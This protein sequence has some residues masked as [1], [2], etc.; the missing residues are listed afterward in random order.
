MRVKTADN[1]RPFYFLRGNAVLGS[2]LRNLEDRINRNCVK[3]CI[4]EPDIARGGRGDNDTVCDEINVPTISHAPLFGSVDRTQ[5]EQRYSKVA[6]ERSPLPVHILSAVPLA[7]R[8]NYDHS[9]P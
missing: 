7:C 9:L 6:T 5:L 1:S 3:S 2:V 4:I 8:T